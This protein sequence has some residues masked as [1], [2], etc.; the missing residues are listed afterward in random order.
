VLGRRA[1]VWP[2]LP[3]PG[4]GTRAALVRQ[5]VLVPSIV[6]GERRVGRLRELP[7]A[8]TTDHRITNPHSES[9]RNGSGD[10]NRRSKFGTYCFNT[11]IG[12]RHGRGSHGR[13][14][15]SSPCTGL[16]VIRSFQRPI[17]IPFFHI[18]RAQHIVVP[19]SHAPTH[20][21]SPTHGHVVPEPHVATE[22]HVVPEPQ[23][24]AVRVP[25]FQK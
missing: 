18:L 2:V 8:P 15:D 23:P 1:A 6:I 9:A 7:S 11:T 12:R 24:Q 17:S 25:L 20:R 5:S 13:S 16:L 4:G 21:Y 10:R 3:V 22:R 14:D 19:Y